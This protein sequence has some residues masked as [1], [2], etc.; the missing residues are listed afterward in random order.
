MT[1]LATEMTDAEYEIARAAAIN[2]RRGMT[3]EDRTFL[4]ESRAA[5][6]AGPKDARDLTDA[7]YE[8]AKAKLIRGS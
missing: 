6:G 1:K 7:E 8:T 2:E 3:A 4:A 5:R